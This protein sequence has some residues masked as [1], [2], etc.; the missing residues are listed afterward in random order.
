MFF[1]KI[2][3]WLA[4]LGILGLVIY[5][6]P[7]PQNWA[8]ASTLQILSLFIP[9]LLSLVLLLYLFISFTQSFIIA[10]GL[11]LTLVLYVISQLNIF[12]IITLLIITFGLTKL[13]KL[14]KLSRPRGRGQRHG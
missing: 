14:P 1:K 3:W 9:L 11:M 13:L 5:F 6:V 12:T 8:E 10:L 4:S 2:L 7:S